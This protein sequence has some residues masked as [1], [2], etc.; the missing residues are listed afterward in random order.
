MSERDLLER[1][2]DNPILTAGDWPYPVNAVF[3][4]AAAVLDGETFCSP[5]SR[6]GAGSPTS[7]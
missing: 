2:P 5:V 6:I 4:P 1:H 3:N 7:P